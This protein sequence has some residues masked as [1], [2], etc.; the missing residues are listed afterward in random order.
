MSRKDYRAFAAM[1]AD[2][3]REGWDPETLAIVASG[4]SAIFAAD[5]P[6]FDRAKFIAAAE[7]I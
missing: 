1:L 4:M 3:G 5:N 7:V 6:R 2:L